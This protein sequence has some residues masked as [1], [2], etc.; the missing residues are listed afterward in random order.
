M[1]KMRNMPFSIAVVSRCDIRAKYADL[2]ERMRCVHDLAVIPFV[3]VLVRIDNGA[4]SDFVGQ[5][6]VRLF[7]YISDIMTVFAD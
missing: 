2:F 6:S 5:D 3:P 1:F 7:K 4:V